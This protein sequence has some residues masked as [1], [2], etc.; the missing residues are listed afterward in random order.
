VDD[1]CDGGGDDG[2]GDG[3]GAVVVVDEVAEVVVCLIPMS[4]DGAMAARTSH[5]RRAPGMVTAMPCGTLLSCLARFVAVYEDP[6][7][8]AD[9][10]FE[11]VE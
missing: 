10:V 7:L 5:T 9:V 11:D 4:S 2:D 6:W 1:D 8:M 3:D